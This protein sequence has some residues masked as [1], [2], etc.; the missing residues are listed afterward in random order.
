[1]HVV[2]WPQFYW[3]AAWGFMP[4]KYVVKVLSLSLPSVPWIHSLW[5]LL[6]Q[7]LM[8][9]L[10]KMRIRKFFKEQ[11]FPFPITLNFFS[12]ARFILFVFK[13]P[14]LQ[15]GMWIHIDCIPIRIQKNVWVRIHITT[16]YDHSILD[17][18]YPFIFSTK[19]KV[20]YN[21]CLAFIHNPH[22]YPGL[23]FEFQGRI[24]RFLRNWLKNKIKKKLVYNKT[25]QF[26]S[27]NLEDNYK[28]NIFQN[29]WLSLVNIMLKIIQT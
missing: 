4:A 9:P 24:K 19:T 17:K 26:F 25:I 12:P 2:L 8:F 29:N 5:R 28:K 27:L 6:K 21:I 1:M 18:K 16:S 20:N 22:R 15:P 13:L 14:M 11:F 7:I 23:F 3:L 10:K